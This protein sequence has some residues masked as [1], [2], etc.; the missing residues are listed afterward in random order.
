METDNSQDLQLASQDSGELMVL[1]Q[2]E[3]GQVRGTGKASFILSPKSW[4]KP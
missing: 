3:S 4:K 2:F 1:F